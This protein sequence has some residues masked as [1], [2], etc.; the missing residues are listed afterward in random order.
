[1]PAWAQEAGRSMAITPTFS[2]SE[3]YTETRSSVTRPN[4]GEFITRISPGLSI[5]SR[6]GRVKGSLNY[7]L[8][9]LHRSEQIDASERQHALSA[10]FTA[11]AVENWAF[12]DTRATISQQSLSAFGQQSAPDSTQANTNRAEVGTASFSPYLRG[13]LGGAVNYEVRLNASINEVRGQSASDSNTTGGSVS[14]SSA[15]TG[16]RLGWAV[17]ANQQTTDYKAGRN[18]SSERANLSLSYRPDHDLQLSLNG[19]QESNDVGAVDQRRYDNWGYGALWKPTERTSVRFQSDRRYFGRSHALSFEHRMQRSSWSY[20]DTRD[21]TSGGDA[22]GVG[23]PITLYEQLFAQLASAQPDPI[24]RE[25]L[26]LDTLRALGR[27]PGEIV[28]GG[29]LNGGV[30]LQRRRDLSFAWLGQ[31]TTFNLQAFASTTRLLDNPNGNPDDGGTQLSGFTS[32]ISYKLTPRSTLNL[33]GSKQITKANLIN[34]GNVLKSASIGLST[35]ASRLI[36]ASFLARYS[37]FN[38]DTAPY[39]ETSVTA[40]LN[41]QFR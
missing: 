7:S 21:S 39:R 17:T 32:T 34:G 28:R 40:T 19:G 20:T 37:V 29:L 36:G 8:N 30:S 1:M 26:V 16:S 23:S 35:Q 12:V 15:S 38:N 5:T 18:T 9:A 25:Q 2:A 10:A 6:S 27:D 11:E 33:N 24:L 41:M 4:G 3:T 22:N 14:L 31:R 13:A